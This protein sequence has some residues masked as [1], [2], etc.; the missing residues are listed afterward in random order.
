MLHSA[1]RVPL[2]VEWGRRCK[3]FIGLPHVDQGAEGQRRRGY[4]FSQTVDCAAWNEA[5]GLVDALQRLNA[6]I[7][8]R[9]ID[10]NLA[11]LKPA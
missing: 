7:K 10:L 8:M 6:P 2:W 1:L 9:H 11:D 5:F 4:P 3:L